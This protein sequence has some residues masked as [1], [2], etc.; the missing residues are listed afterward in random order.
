M[1]GY[2]QYVQYF[3][4]QH[5]MKKSSVL[6]IKQGRNG[7]GREVKRENDWINEWEKGGRVKGRGCRRGR[8][9]G[10]GWKGQVSEIQIRLKK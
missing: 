10:Q 5:N 8:R 3:I 1:L 7:E 4:E 9:G 6:E 2:L